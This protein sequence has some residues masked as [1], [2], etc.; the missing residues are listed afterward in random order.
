MHNT[1]HA[2]LKWPVG[3]KRIPG[4]IVRSPTIGLERRV[5]T[6]SINGMPILVIAWGV[7]SDDPGAAMKKVKMFFEHVLNS[8]RHGSQIYGSL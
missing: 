7:F 8:S 6:F 1:L 5:R 3:R 2:E 4:Q